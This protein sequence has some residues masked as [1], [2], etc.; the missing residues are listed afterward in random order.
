MWWGGWG[1]LEW[2]LRW[3]SSWCPWREADLRRGMLSAAQ[4]LMAPSALK[5]HVVAGCMRGTLPEG[6]KAGG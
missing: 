3:W 2:L 4:Q 5:A 1:W 6:L